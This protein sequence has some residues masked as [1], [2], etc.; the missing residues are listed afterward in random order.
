MGIAIV[1]AGVLWIFN[2]EKVMKEKIVTSWNKKYR[3]VNIKK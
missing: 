3:L 2:V 1:F